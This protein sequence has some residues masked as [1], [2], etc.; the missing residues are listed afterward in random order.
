[1]TLELSDLDTITESALKNFEAR[2]A[3]ADPSHPVEI[4]WEAARL[5]SQLEQLYSFTAL[6]ARREP[7]MAR[8]AEL[9]AELVKTCDLFAGRVFRLAQQH[10]LNLSAYD[11][12][13]D[14]RGAA[15]ELRALHSQ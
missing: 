4:E 13:G 10:A 11:R 6:L 9:W 2:L 1:M 15:E 3:K 12:I 8:T 7:D 14:I 5:E